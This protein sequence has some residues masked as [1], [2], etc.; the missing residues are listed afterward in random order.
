MY[1]NGDLG[2]VTSMQTHPLWMKGVKIKQ[3][4]T[5]RGSIYSNLASLKYLWDSDANY[6]VKSS[7]IMG[8]YD[9]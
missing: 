5:R 1:E 7:K 8:Y 6:G 9:G 3:F 4:L 2:C